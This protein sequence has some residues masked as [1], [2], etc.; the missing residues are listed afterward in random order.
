VAPSESDPLATVI[1]IGSSHGEVLERCLRQLLDQDY[2]AY[3]VL[4]VCDGDEGPAR[5][6]IRGAT[7]ERVVR[8]LDAPAGRG[9]SHACNIGLRHARGEVVVFIDADGFAHHSWLS[10]LVRAL[11]THGSIGGAASTVFFASNPLVINGA[12]GVINQRGFSAYLSMNQSYERAQIAEEALYP[13]GCG[14]ALTRV[15]AE[16]VGAFDGRLTD[17]Y[18][19]VDYGI[20]LWRAGYRVAV[21][22]GAWI[23][24]GFFGYAGGPSPRDGLGL[25][26]E[27]VRVMLKHTPS[28]SLPS[29]LRREIAATAR[30]P[31]AARR[32]RLKALAWNVVNAGGLLAGRWSLR[33]SAAVPQRLIDDSWTEEFPVEAPPSVSPLPQRAGHVVN[34]ADPGSA[35]QLPYGWF[36]PEHASGRCYRWAA[37]QAAALMRVE[38]PAKRLR[39][40][41]AHVPVDV[42]GVDVHIRAAGSR[43]PLRSVWSTHLGWQY[44]ERSVEN[45]PLSLPAGD[46]EVIFSA[47]RGWSEPP[48][49]CRSLAFALE[50]LSLEDSLELPIGGI[51]MASPEVEE[52]LVNGW[53]E[54]EQAEGGSYRW[55][56]ARAEALV[57]VVERAA[58]RASLTYRFPGR[59]VGQAQVSM[60]PSGARSPVWRECIPWRDGNWHVAELALQLPRGDYVVRFEVATTWSNADQ[61]DSEMPPENRSLGMAISSL[62]LD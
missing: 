47:D 33:G 26:R 56:A 1:V 46:Y 42:G 61:R 3:E 45:H 18:A 62:H 10:L 12:G 55:T 22:S 9:R 21:A 40:R 7:A 37:R 19:E 35:G 15:A 54:A 14:M 58:T 23:D 8:V 31:R 53:F 29:W 25:E 30:A 27:R 36:P 49:G 43:Q 44:I 60:L 4:L 59:T 13:M 6:L 34:M 28:R 20:R 39:L 50:Y 16:R 51:D 5:E 38:M 32:A 24:H 41:Y 17:S 48:P 11:R 52:Q 57:R 2:A